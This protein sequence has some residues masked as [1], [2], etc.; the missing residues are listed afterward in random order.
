M[1]RSEIYRIR[2]TIAATTRTSI[3]RLRAAKEGGKVSEAA[4]YRARLLTMLP[5]YRQMLI[6]EYGFNYHLSISKLLGEEETCDCCGA[7]IWQSAM[8]CD[9][10]QPKRNSDDPNARSGIVLCAPCY[11]DGR[12]CRCKIMKPAQVK[13]LTTLISLMSEAREVLK[14]ADGTDHELFN[15]ETWESVGQPSTTSPRVWL[16]SANHP[17]YF[18]LANFLRDFRI[19]NVKYGGSAKATTRMVSLRLM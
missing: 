18:R 6:E 4:Q 9:D 5:L 12:S 7:D 8:V 11:V 13:T 1:C 3:E 19:H 2:A 16:T 17:P 14:H 15:S 10:C